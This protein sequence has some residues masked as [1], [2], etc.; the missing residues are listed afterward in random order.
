MQMLHFYFLGAFG[1]KAKT[2]LMTFGVIGSNAKT[3][4]MILGV[5][6]SIAKTALMTAIEI[7]ALVLPVMGVVVIM[8]MV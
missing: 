4:L 7:Y 6:G 1:S 2:A 3:A 5:I 8:L